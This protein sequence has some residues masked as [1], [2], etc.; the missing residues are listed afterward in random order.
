MTNGIGLF[1][2]CG[3]IYMATTSC[4][5]SYRID[6]LKFEAYLDV[7]SDISMEVV[8]PLSTYRSN[9]ECFMEKTSSDVDM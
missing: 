5:F 4:S 7:G 9:D 2:K 3:S 1:M 8:T 6:V